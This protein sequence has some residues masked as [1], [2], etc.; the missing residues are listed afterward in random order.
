[1]E[2]SAETKVE[3][4]DKLTKMDFNFRSMSN[5]PSLQCCNLL[6]RG[7]VNS[8]RRDGYSDADLARELNSMTFQE[9]QTMEEEIHGVSTVIKETPEF[10]EQKIQEMM[11][12][13]EIIPQNEG[14][15][16]WD[17]AVFLRPA[18]GSDKEH[19][20]MFLRARRFDP[21][22]AAVLMINFY[23]LKRELYGEDC[24]IHRICWTDLTPEE[25]ELI[26]S[27]VYRII[28]SRE[29]SGRGIGYN[30]MRKWD[31]RNTSPMAFIRSSQ[32]LTINTIQDNP[33]LQRH[34]IVNVVDLRN[35]FDGSNLQANLQLIQFVNQLA[36]IMN[37]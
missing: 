1:M 17:R 33:D 12:Q 6:I 20:L 25:Q 31:V 34:G 23:E 30:P 4:V 14:R 27:G 22:A 11:A 36:P 3:E 10:V 21:E 32:F 19:F 24:L 5:E 9:R 26:R 15:S 16:A 18:L 29:R 7:K 37:R 2:Y 28:L 13:L 8:E 35:I